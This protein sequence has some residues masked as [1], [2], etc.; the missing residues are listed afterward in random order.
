MSTTV[1]MTLE[2]IRN[3]PLSRD[4]I[5]AMHI[6]AE[7]AV[8]GQPQEDPD[9]PVQTHEQL[10][11]FRPLKDVMPALYAKLHPEEASLPP[12]KE[13]EAYGAQVC[14]A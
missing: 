1:T 2:E 3:T 4:E 9:C 11:Q 6:A 5:A 12:S 14:F 10:K 8:R 7:R 13:R